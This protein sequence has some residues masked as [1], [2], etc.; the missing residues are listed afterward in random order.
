MLLSLPRHVLASALLALTLLAPAVAADT[1]A[2]PPATA[3]GPAADLARVPAFDPAPGDLAS[4]RRF[5]LPN[6]LKV[7]LLSDPK[8]NQSSASLAVGVGYL[9]DPPQRAGLAHFLEH[10]LFLGTRKYPDITDFAGYLGRNG[11]YNNAY[12][13]TDRTNFHFEI[14][15][16]AFEGALDRFA[17]FFIDP[18]F[19]PRF[20]EREMNAVASEHQKNLESD[21]WRQH[22]LSTVMYRAD[23]PA[24]KFGTGSRATLQGTTREELLDFYRR[25]YSANRMTLALTG[26]A[27]LDQLEQ[28]ARTHFA[29]VPNHQ[30]PP[31][32][33]AETY[34]DRNPALRMLR[35]EPLKDL[36]LLHL[37]FPL[38]A[39]RQQWPH[40]SAELLAYV[41]GHEG[42]GSLLASLK[43]EGLAASLGASAQPATA[44]F[45]SLEL[46]IGL[47]PEGLARVPRVLQQVFAMIRLLREQGLPAHV[48]AERQAMARL[49]ER[50]RD[51]GEGANR[52]L[53]LANLLMDHPLE[54]AERVPFLWLREDRAAQRALLDRL[55]PDN[56]LVTLVAKGQPTDRT[57]PVYG[58][59]YS[60]LEDGGAAYT[61]LLSPPVV[62]AL[63][64]PPPNGF[65]PQR[66][67]QLP[68]Q[69]ARLVDEP[70]LTMYYAQDT[71]FQRPLAAH[72]LR[73]RLPRSMAS[74][75]TAVLL[76]F[77]EACVRESL[78]EITYTAGDAG[79]NFR[80]A[81]SLDGVLIAAE[82]Y[83]DT[84]GRLLDTAAG[85]LVDLRIDEQRFSAL[86]DL[87][88]R[89]LAAAPLADAYLTVA[90]T[91]RAAVREF[92]Y[93]ASEQLPLAR[94][95]T[96]EQ[97]RRFAREL[98]ARG[99]LEALSY[100]NVGAD[101]AQ[102]AVRRVA[103]VLKTQPVADAELLRPHRL[104]QRAGDSLRTSEPLQVNNSAFRREYVLGGD[105][106]EMRAATLVLG[107]FLSDPFYAELRTRQQLGYIVYGSAADDERQQ[108]AY[109][110]VQSGEVP[111]DEIERRVDAYLAGEPAR[112]AG[113]S[114]EAWQALVG[115]ARAKLE[116][117]DKSIAERAMRLFTLAY[118]RNADW[119]RRAATL[120]ALQ[121]LTPARAAEILRQAF[122]PETRR[123]RTFLGFAREHRPASPPAVTFSDRDGWKRA[124]RYE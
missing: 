57:E 36:R 23:H 101:A 29:A 27:S 63:R 110:I 5:V 79:L 95:V 42:P 90:E 77:Y 50:F 31:L 108:F 20:T 68:V 2:P 30:L 11:G 54:V 75:R 91:R 67:S 18:L 34:F 25:H 44:D 39:L 60:V 99:K 14:R 48:F 83:D 96:L 81:A 71:E 56:L 49:D 86:K 120:Q 100:G 28:W 19:D 103:A 105:T 84:V 111:P 61:A 121:Q 123:M 109:F 1:A 122:A 58:T 93:L 53:T 51:K 88:L 33:Y 10:M 102:Y 98:V 97:V 85:H 16:E 112:L 17:Q 45:G 15:H 52:A 37:E 72:L 117:Q 106:P 43:A 21:G 47:T 118:E 89:Q 66:T 65:V 78:N 9:E 59:R 70:A 64:P 3:V 32:R 6:G 22:F 92:H 76:H 104:V 40:K 24:H 35:M 116:E 69:P 13:S 119:D 74:L 26:R 8:L 55:T 115:G 82:G 94:E 38:P 124:Q 62:A 41:L 107:A 113:V 73:L 12:T 7:I 80:V 46:Q 87:L 114:P 4:W